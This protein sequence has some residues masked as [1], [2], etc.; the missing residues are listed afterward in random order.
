MIDLRKDMQHLGNIMNYIQNEGFQTVL[1]Q[2]HYGRNVK[3]NVPKMINQ[4]QEDETLVR[5]NNLE[6][7]TLKLRRTIWFM[8]KGALLYFPLAVL[9]YLN[10]SF[11]RW[12]IVSRIV[13]II[14]LLIITF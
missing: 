2:V 9:D 10:E 7:L 13:L 3:Q 5:Q 14:N 4:Q 11:P 8:Q 1:E 6:D 12:W